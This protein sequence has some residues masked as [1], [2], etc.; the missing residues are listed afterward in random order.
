MIMFLIQNREFA[1][2]CLRF[3]GQGTGLWEI[4][5]GSENTEFELLDR[6]PGEGVEQTVQRVREN[7]AKIRQFKSRNKR[8]VRSQI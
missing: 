5:F 7:G 3:K 6:F 8:I 1:T 4:E 2:S